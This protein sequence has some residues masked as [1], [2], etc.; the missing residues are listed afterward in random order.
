MTTVSGRNV[1]AGGS[2]PHCT[3]SCAIKCYV[4]MVG[5]V[6]RAAPCPTLK[7]ITRSSAATRVTIQRTI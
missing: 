7:S 3:K 4:A 5:A 1:R 2:I 6:S